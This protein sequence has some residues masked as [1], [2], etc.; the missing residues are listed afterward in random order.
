MCQSFKRF[1]IIAHMDDNTQDIPSQI[2]TGSSSRLSRTTENGIT[3]FDGSELLR[4]QTIPKKQRM[5]LRFVVLIAIIIGLGVVFLV[6]NTLVIEPMRQQSDVTSNIVRDVDYGIPR[7][8]QYTDY[9]N[10]GIYAAEGEHEHVLIWIPGGDNDNGNLDVMKIPQD[11]TF[12][13]G[14]E[15]LNAGIGNLSRDQQALMLKGSF[16]LTIDRSNGLTMRVRYADFESQSFEEAINRALES[17]SFEEMNSTESGV[18]TS[19][20]TYQAG[21]FK[22]GDDT[23]TWRVSVV[24]LDEVYDLKLDRKAFYFGIRIERNPK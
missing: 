19:G 1:G 22:R 4:E 12:E 14:E 21:T 8:S 20:N 6:A 16:R 15:L 23:Y 5:P 10:D 18:D 3:A 2:R 7:L 11:M 24:E 9:D 17:Q 13:R